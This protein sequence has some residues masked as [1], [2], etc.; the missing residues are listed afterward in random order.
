MTGYPLFATEPILMFLYQQAA[1]IEISKQCFI[2]KPSAC[3]GLDV[4][5]ESAWK[6]SVFGVFLVLIFPYLDWIRRD[7]PYPSVFS[8][9]AGKYRPEKLWMRTLFVQWEICYSCL[10]FYLHDKMNIKVYN[11]EKVKPLDVIKAKFY[12]VIF[13][14]IFLPGSYVLKLFRI[15]EIVDICSSH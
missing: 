14:N 4:S 13:L 3:Y 7:T 2:I 9:N 10:L 8:P 12:D 1:I 5:I 11:M 15:Y 6:V